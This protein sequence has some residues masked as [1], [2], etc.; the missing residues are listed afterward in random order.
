MKH[1][2]V[3]ASTCVKH[4]NK[5]LLGAVL[6][7]G[8]AAA[9]L[10]NPDLSFAINPPAP[11]TFAY[12]LYDIAVE[13]ILKGPVGYVGGMAA[14]VMGAIALI[15]GRVLPAIPAVLGGAAL[16]KADTLIQGIGLLF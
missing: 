9:I 14:M 16:L 10:M 12:D 4:Q 7:V 3:G 13:K 15:T 11:G 5:L 6:A 8:A 2:V 1:E